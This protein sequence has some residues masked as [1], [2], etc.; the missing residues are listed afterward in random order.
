[1]PYLVV[2]HKVKSYEKWKDGFDKDEPNRWAGGSKG[3][4]VLRGVDDPSEVVV[5][6]EWDSFKAL[7]EFA[8][9]DELRE[10]MKREGVLDEADVFVADLADRPVM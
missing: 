6:L 4:M 8:F 2:R 10:R 3:G 9:S 7:R 1:M 5:F